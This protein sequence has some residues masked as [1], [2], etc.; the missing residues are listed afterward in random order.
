MKVFQLLAFINKNTKNKLRIPLY[1]IQ[2]VVY[3]FIK[4]VLPDIC[5]SYKIL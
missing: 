2:G 1:I 3:K 5:F 4:M